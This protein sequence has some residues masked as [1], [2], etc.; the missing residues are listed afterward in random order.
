MG[1]NVQL[2]PL[3]CSY[4]HSSGFCPTCDGNGFTW[5]WFRDHSGRERQLCVDCGGSGLCQACRVRLD[6][7]L[8][9]QRDYSD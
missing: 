5:L 3:A 1:S 9:G 6:V 4:C 7:L 2:E 8:D